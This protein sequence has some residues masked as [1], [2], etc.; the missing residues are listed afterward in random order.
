[1]MGSLMQINIASKQFIHHQQQYR[2]CILLIE[3]NTGA[4]NPTD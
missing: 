4:L 2:T 3:V 1:M